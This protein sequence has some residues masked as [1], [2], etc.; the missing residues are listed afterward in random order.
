MASMTI[1]CC[2]IQEDYSLG[3]R[4]L[5]PPRLSLHFLN[6][7][8]R[9]F[10]VINGKLNSATWELTDCCLQKVYFWAVVETHNMEK[11][12]G[13][14]ERQESFADYLPLRKLLR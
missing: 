12:F 5:K 2:P 8:Y 3:C 10:N 6:G 4:D 9:F 14:R 13:T 11:T 7:I 1:Q